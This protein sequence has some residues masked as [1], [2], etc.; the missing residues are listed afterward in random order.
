MNWTGY[1]GQY[2]YTKLS[3][4]N[5]VIITDIGAKKTIATIVPEAAQ[6]PFDREWGEQFLA[7]FNRRYKADLKGDFPDTMPVIRKIWVTREDHLVICKWPARPSWR[8]EES[9]CKEDLLV[10]NKIGNPIPNP[11]LFDLHFLRVAHLDETRVAVNVYNAGLDEYSIVL[12]SREAFAD[13]IAA[14]PSMAP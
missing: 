9:Y 6:L 14:Y 1:S 11:S 10:Y 2:A 8:A 4:R 5:E 12:G 3:G 13:I 7:D